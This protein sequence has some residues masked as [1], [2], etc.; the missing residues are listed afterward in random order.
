[1]K[2]NEIKQLLDTFYRG[3]STIEEENHLR[4]F[5]TGDVPTDF[6]EEKEYFI[7]IIGLEKK[8]KQEIPHNLE[9]NLDQWFNSLEAPIHKPINRTIRFIWG[10]IA[11]VA[12]MLA[13][14][15]IFHSRPAPAPTEALTAETTLTE[16]QKEELVLA[17][18]M[19]SYNLNKGIQSLEEIPRTL[20]YAQEMINNY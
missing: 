20:E 19:V 2:T 14:V 9:E 8:S 3:E 10:S 13:L 4:K 16:E 11:G 1:M 18:E 17:L 15:W 6:E 12:A 5:F 7:Q